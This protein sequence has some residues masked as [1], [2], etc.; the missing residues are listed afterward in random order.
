L[1]TNRD[2]RRRR[3]EPGSICSVPDILTAGNFG[4][5]TYSCDCSNRSRLDCI[6][7]SS[8]GSIRV[9][10]P[11]I[12]GRQR[13]LACHPKSRGC[14]LFRIRAKSNLIRSSKIS[15]FGSALR[16]YFLGILRTHV[17]IRALRRSPVHLLHPRFAPSH[18]LQ[19]STAPATRCS[20]RTKAWRRE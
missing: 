11:D 5:G 16:K 4:R 8:F 20:M 18:F 13:A 6:G 7:S 12:G 2:P 1:P 17:R 19:R 9:V 3:R 15:F 14:D 10:V